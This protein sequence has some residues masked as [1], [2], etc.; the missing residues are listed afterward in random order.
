VPLVKDSSKKA[1][2]ANIAT[3][4]REDKRPQ[5]Q[6]IAIAERVAGKASPK[7]KGKR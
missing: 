4:I 5:K 6:A 7:P 2:S 1:V 3:L